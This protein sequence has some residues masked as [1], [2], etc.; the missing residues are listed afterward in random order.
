MPIIRPIVG[1]NSKHR[2]DISDPL[3]QECLL[4]LHGDPVPALTSKLFK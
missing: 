3:L 2:L 4:V 1:G